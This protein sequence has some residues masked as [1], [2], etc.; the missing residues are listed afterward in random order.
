V[1]APPLTVQATDLTG[2]TTPIDRLEVQP[3]LAYGYDYK[4][5]TISYGSGPAADAL[6]L[7]QAFGAILSPKGGQHPT[8]RYFMHNLLGEVDQNG[9]PVHFGTFQTTDPR[10]ESQLAAWADSAEGM[11]YDFLTNIS[12]TPPAGFS[13]P[14]TDPAGSWSDAGASAPTSGAPPASSANWNVG[15]G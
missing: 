14:C 11:G 8:I 9:Q 4:P 7:S 1:V 12:S 2:V 13:T 3:N 6:G 5:S 10:L 15:H